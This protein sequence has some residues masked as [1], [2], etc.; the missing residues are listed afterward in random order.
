MCGIFSVKGRS[1]TP[2]HIHE[3]LKKLQYRGYDS[4]GYIVGT[5][6]KR[7]TG[8][9]QEEYDSVTEFSSTFGMG[10][11]RWATHGNP[12]EEKNTHPIQFGKNNWF[13]VHNGIIQNYKQLIDEY[14]L[15]HTSDTD[16]EVIVS[17]AEH[18]YRE[19]CYNLKRIVEQIVNV[20][21]GTYAF[22]LIS[23]S[24]FPEEVIS[25]CKG[26]PL[27]VSESDDGIIFTSDQVTLEPHSKYFYAKHGDIIHVKSDGTYEIDDTNATIYTAFS[28]E[29]DSNSSYS[30][31]MLKEITEQPDCIRNMFLGRVLNND[32]VLLGDKEPYLKNAKT[33]VLI[34]CGSSYNACLV[35]RP[36]LEKYKIIHVELASDFVLRRPIIDT[37]STVYIVV[38]QSGETRDCI[39]ACE[40]ISDECRGVCLGINNRPGSLLDSKTRAGMHLNIGTE[41]SVPATKSFTATVIA[42]LMFAAV[43]ID[44]SKIPDLLEKH[45]QRMLHK[46]IETIEDEDSDIWVIGDSWG[47]GVAKELTLKLQEV[48]YI[49]ASFTTG[50]EMKHGP[51]ALIDEKSHVFY[52]G[53]HGTNIPDILESRGA[54]IVHSSEHNSITQVL[55]DIINIQLVTYYTA[56]KKNLPIDT[57]RNLAKSVTV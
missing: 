25:T 21:E 55:C 16:T 1:V 53:P 14:S 37:E 33:W 26:S 15:K 8:K 56:L 32:E 3:G 57:P 44:F 51:I 10:H 41:I 19:G 30:H 20:I 36:F 24:Y 49:K 42:L 47:L 29:K 22:I 5:E 11:T 46:T 6:Y 50:Y 35:A 52:F 18:F 23:P 13:V 34:G 4:W 7:Y 28:N 45:I 2:K 43:S 40:Y 9:I 27:I 48:A 38:S 17:L 54:K 31:H 12:S 39:A